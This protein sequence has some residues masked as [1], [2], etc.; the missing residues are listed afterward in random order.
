M[1]YCGLNFLFC[2]VGILC[3]NLLCAESFH[4]NKC[5]ETERRAR[6]K[7]KDALIYGNFSS[8]KGED[9]CKWEGIPCNNF[10]GHV[11]GLYVQPPYLFFEFGG[12]KLDSSIC[13]QK[14]LIFFTLRYNIPRRKDTKVHRFT[15]SVDRVES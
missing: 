15:W 13:E 7:F 14:H 12:G 2:M 1:L 9:C 3:I 11:P 4:T 10:T 6:L 5:A 8:W